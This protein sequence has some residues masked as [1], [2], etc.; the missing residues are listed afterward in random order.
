M[1]P[2][3]LLLIGQLVVEAARRVDFG[4]LASVVNALRESDDN[5]LDQLILLA[6]LEALSLSVTT[7]RALKETEAIRET[8]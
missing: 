3:I 6:K 5:D 8:S 1:T 2:A 7:D 4:V